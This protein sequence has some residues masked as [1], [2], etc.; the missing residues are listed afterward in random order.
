MS[1]TETSGA[2]LASAATSNPPAAFG[3]S[4]GSGLARGKRAASPAAAPAPAP[5]TGEYRPTAI[6]VITPKSDYQN[7]FAE[8]APA[9][10]A[11][12]EIK[13][14]AAAAPAPASVESKEIK[15]TPP[16]AATPAPAPTENRAQLNIL[17][18]EE[19]KR[20]SLSWENGSDSSAPPETRQRRDERPVF[21]PERRE[22]KPFEAREPRA[23]EPREPRELRP[24]QKPFEG[25]EPREPRRDA[26][27]EPRDFRR[28]PAPETAPKKS[29]G[30][31]GWL[32]NLFGGEKPAET[33]GNGNAAPEGERNHDGHHGHHRRRHR[34]GR[35]RGG[36]RDGAPR[37]ENQHRREGG[38]QE[39][40]GGERRHDG[41][42]HRRRR[43]GGRGR[44]FRPG[45]EGGH[46]GP[47]T[48]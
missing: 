22:Q 44:N 38:G 36:F 2:P 35:G 19:S 30:F 17:P 13:S 48:S 11:K 14:T 43:R 26:S 9:A 33:S 16:A 7:P 27:V 25:R 28:A 23:F 10:P 40:N 41:G 21:R 39:Q 45:G 31:F 3:T 42:G 8:P 5:S 34:G 24:E 6:E 47:P 20:S 1:E 37:G 15:P 18:P 46:G 29:G 4:R 12:E 32:K